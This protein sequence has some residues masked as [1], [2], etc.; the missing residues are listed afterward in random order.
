MI[1]QVDFRTGWNTVMIGIT[2]KSF[3][4]SWDN[5]EYKGILYTPFEGFKESGA[6][7]KFAHR[8]IDSIEI[9]ARASVAQYKVNS[10]WNS[11]VGLTAL[12]IVCL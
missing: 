1:E 11:K 10:T 5:F 8:P 7:V 6:I 2:G 3:Y 9:E 12:Q 4:E